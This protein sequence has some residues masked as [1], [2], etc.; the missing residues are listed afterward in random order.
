M[1]KVKCPICGW[2][3]QKKIVE[4]QRSNLQSRY[5]HGV[6]LPILSDHT[7]YTEEEMKAVLKYKFHIKHT[8]ELDTASFEEFMSEI[9]RWAS[10]ELECWI[11][12]PNEAISGE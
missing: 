8:S 11:P 10:A 4:K 7:G 5:F 9:R 12:E 6:I 1:A 3:F 2:I